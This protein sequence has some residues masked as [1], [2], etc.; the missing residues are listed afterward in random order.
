MFGQSFCFEEF[1][2]FGPKNDKYLFLQT[3]HF[4]DWCV[5]AGFLLTDAP[6]VWTPHCLTSTSC[7]DSSNCFM[8][9]I[10][11]I[12]VG[13]LDQYMVFTS[14]CL[15]YLEEGWRIVLSNSKSFHSNSKE[16]W[17]YETQSVEFSS[18]LFGGGK[19]HLVPYR[20]LKP[21]KPLY[22]YHH[23][24]LTGLQDIKT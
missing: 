7:A 1:D 22:V 13:Y 8:L 19:I 5:V 14:I 11:L 18:L 15:L 3:S 12:T 24:M 2:G 20:G 16:I 17:R 21:Q 9:I 23:S 6:A 4:P 10:N